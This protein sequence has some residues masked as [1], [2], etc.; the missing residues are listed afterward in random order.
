[1]TLNIFFLKKLKWMPVFLF[2]VSLLISTGA[3][4]QS[5]ITLKV[6][7]YQNEP[8]IFTDQSGNP[9][10]FWVDILDEIAGQQGWVLQY[11]PGTWDDGLSR[12]KAGE[13]DIMPDVAY[14]DE[15]E[16]LFDFNAE[17]VYTSWSGVYAKAGTTV[18]SLIDLNGKRIAVM[19]QSINYIGG[20]GIKNLVEAFDIHCVFIEKVSY[21][22][23]FEAVDS[24]E[25]DAGV[26]S[27]DFAISNLSK[28]EL[29]STPIIFQPATLYFVFPKGAT[30]NQEL[31][32]VIDDEINRLKADK[33]SIYHQLMA[34]WFH[35]ESDHIVVP[36][37]LYWLM[38]TIILVA[39]M[40]AGGS[41]VLR[42][43]V[44]QR[45]AEL[46]AEI[47]E[48]KKAEDG[49]KESKAMLE[50]TVAVRTAEL[51]QSNE[52]LERFA[53]I[54]SHDL[55]EPLRMVTSYL[56]LLESRY[57]NK[58]DEDANDFIFY[59]V[60]GAKRMQ[61]LINDLLKYSRVDTRQKEHEPVDCNE[62][63]K[64]VLSNLE[65]AI[66]ESDAE[67]IAEP[68]PV[69]SGDDTQLRQLFQNLIGN[70]IKFRR[71]EPLK[72][73]ISS[74][75]EGDSWRFTIR[76]NGI[77]IDE[78]YFDRIFQVFQRLHGSRKYKGNGIGLAICKKIV[79]NHGGTI[80]V[81]SV[82]GSGSRFTFSIA[83]KGA[84]HA[85]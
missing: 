11:V 83:K 79:E 17:S 42:R 9:S 52:E 60:D 40:L 4:S 51:K 20:S 70:A 15:R 27:K 30:Q 24:G 56:Q 36:L 41:Q 23:V 76:D 22:E 72:I 39:V 2:A 10:G 48:R 58:L 21:G 45:T 61:K 19:Q 38:G 64:E 69:V 8:K 68:L 34:K 28:Y 35:V 49:L 53:Y 18:E 47:A 59:A 5:T 65:I 50:E 44:R 26:T 25:A 3:F 7:L 54:T 73:E 13:L 46:T 63:L 14:N 66:N 81:V 75:E 84:A 55:Q 82:P 16:K 77:G 12:L 85:E 78:K 33:N 71:D 32:R 67:I 43:Q 57:K 29:I 80:G 37:W 6:G 31:I 74:V 62:I 1:M